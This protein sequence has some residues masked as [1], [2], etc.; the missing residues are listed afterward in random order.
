[1]LVWNVAEEKVE[2]PLRVGQM[3]RAMFSGDGRWLATFGN[4][5]ELRETGTWKLAPPLPFP[6]GRPVLGAP[7]FSPDGRVLAVVADHSTIHLIDLQRFQSLAILR[8][9]TTVNLSGLSFSPDG[10]SLAAVGEENRAMVW[11]LRELR[12]GLAQLDLDW[13]LPPLPWKASP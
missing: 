6:E 8:P 4:V 2:K 5:L 7:A 13:D 10:T 3:P 9:P 11:N 12:R 1:M